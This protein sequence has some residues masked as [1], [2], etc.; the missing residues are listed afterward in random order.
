MAGHTVVFK[1]I[2]IYIYRVI[3]IFF[4]LGGFSSSGVGKNFDPDEKQRIGMNPEIKTSGH[5]LFKAKS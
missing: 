3:C 5:C 4:Y 1:N 2:Y